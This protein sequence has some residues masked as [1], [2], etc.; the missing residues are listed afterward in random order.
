[1]GLF[2][3]RKKVRPQGLFFF[4][5][6]GYFVVKFQGGFKIHSVFDILVLNFVCE[7]CWDVKPM[8]IH[9]GVKLKGAMYPDW[10]DLT[11]P[12]SLKLTAKA[13]EYRSF[14]PKRKVIFQLLFFRGY[15]SLREC[16]WL[17]IWGSVTDCCSDWQVVIF[18]L[19]RHSIF[20]HFKDQQI[21]ASFEYLSIH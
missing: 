20:T 11:L 7:T 19:E 4:G 3:L 8:K 13:S 12:D 16:N 6:G 10:L 2:C 21:Y 9:G 5:G 15:D 14:A 18:L 1:M 17:K